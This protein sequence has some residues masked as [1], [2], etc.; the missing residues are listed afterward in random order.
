MKGGFIG[1]DIF[2]VISGFLI[3]T[4]I[5]SSLEKDSFSFIEFYSRR[6]RR[7]FPA[8][9]FVLTFSLVFGWFALLADEYKQLG[10]HTKSAA[11]FY[12]NFV[13][14]K[15][16]GYFDNASESKPLLHL[17]SLA[18]EEQFYLI[19]PLLLW[20]AWKKRF[21]LLTITIVI[22]LISFKLN[23]SKS[24]YNMVVDFYSPQ[25]RFW[26]L[27][28]GSILAYINLR[29]WHFF[30]RFKHKLDDWLSKIIYFNAPKNNGKTL[31]DCQTM[32]GAVFIFLGLLITKKEDFPGWWALLPTFGAVLII[33]AGLHAWFNRKV[34]S[35]RVLV[36]F[37]WISFPLYL[38]HWV[39]LSFARIME[40]DTPIWQI[41]LSA[42]LLSILLAWLTYRFVEKPMRFGSHGNAKTVVLLVLMVIVGGTGSYIKKQNGFKFRFPKLEQTHEQFSWGTITN[43]A[44]VSK[45]K[46]ED[47]FCMANKIQPRPV[48][49][50]LGDSH[51]NRLY[52]GVS[53]M[54]ISLV[55]LGIGGCLGL[56]NAQAFE[57]TSHP[58][59][60]S[61]T[62]DILNMALESQ[63]AKVIV[64]S[65]FWL[66]HSIEKPEVSDIFKNI[67]RGTIEKFLTKNKKVIFVLDVPTLGFDPKSCIE[68]HPLKLAAMKTPCAISR[69]SFEIATKNYK[70]LVLSVLKDYPTVRIFD[71]AA[72]LCD[73]KYCWAMKD[74][75]L[76]YIDAEH[77]SVQ[78]SEFIGKKL[79][80]LIESLL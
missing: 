71:A 66:A 24:Q 25:T 6:I 57:N 10:Q 13:L 11:L 56:L 16:S 51:S 28:I 80:P 73:D 31:R 40:S 47:P 77:L 46:L 63:S 7:I 12:S 62:N 29:Q 3:S 45:Y 43:P 42:V 41:R 78:G 18:I 34:L 60:S 79:A 5:I 65:S 38:W 48:V 37:G 26:E 19:W 23:I 1:V 20:A 59:C 67:L 8:L 52:Y 30:P 69:K 39:L 14:W 35:N 64:L 33:S 44:C 49:M 2:F 9:I 15:E 17:W 50:L 22:A 68:T 32:L 36:W 76:L 53:S 75:E 72:E 27:L 70:Q 54:R 58:W 61:R 4:I 74:G 21:N 55:S